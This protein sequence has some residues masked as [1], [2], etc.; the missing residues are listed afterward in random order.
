[1]GLRRGWGISFWVFKL[2]VWGSFGGDN[3]KS[4]SESK[5]QRNAKA[6]AER[7]KGIQRM[8][9]SLLRFGSGVLV[10]VRM[11]L[12]WTGGGLR[13]GSRFLR[14]AA[15]DEAVSSFGRNDVS[16]GCGGE[17]A[18]SYGRFALV[19]C[20]AVGGSKKVWRLWMG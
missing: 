1:M 8:W 17:Q 20:R 9:G 14:C 13:A 7:R 12:L 11:W 10:V 19:S 16:F 2:E 18:T 6:N 4:K 15:H 5:T 3:E